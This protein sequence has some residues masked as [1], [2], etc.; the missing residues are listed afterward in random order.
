MFFNLFV[1]LVR[2]CGRGREDPDGLEHLILGFFVLSSILSFAVYPLVGYVFSKED[3]ELYKN[4]LSSLQK[5]LPTSPA[6]IVGWAGTGLFLHLVTSIGFLFVFLPS[7]IMT[8]YVVSATSWM[9][10][11]RKLW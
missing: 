3:L 9:T 6:L 2:S 8:I 1:I 11:L 5:F 10:M 4:F 7:T